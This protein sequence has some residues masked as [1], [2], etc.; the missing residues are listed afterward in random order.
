MF[1]KIAPYWSRGPATRHSPH[2]RAQNVNDRYELKVS[3]IVPQFVTC[4]LMYVKRPLSTD[5][6]DEWCCTKVNNLLY[7]VCNC[8]FYRLYIIN[9]VIVMKDLILLIGI[10]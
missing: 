1:M 10:F 3:F 8:S 6:S 9:F 5:T 4:L 7:N 2:K